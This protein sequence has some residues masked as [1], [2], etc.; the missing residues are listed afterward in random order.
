MKTVF[1]CFSIPRFCQIP[2]NQMLTTNTRAV[3]HKIFFV[4]GPLK[5]IKCSAKHKILILMGIRGPPVVRGADLWN[6]CT[7]ASQLWCFH[8]CVS[9]I[10]YFNCVQ[11]IRSQIFRA[12]HKPKISEKAFFGDLKK[13][14]KK[15]SRTEKLCNNIRK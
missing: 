3:V 12:N 1:P 14:K 9:Q 10:Y 8:I 4:R 11:C 15:I 13:A 7:R 2:W 6:H 5:I